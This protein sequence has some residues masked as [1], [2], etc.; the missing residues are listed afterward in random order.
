MGKKSA[1]QDGQDVHLQMIRGS[2]ELYNVS[3]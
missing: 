3:D 2:T 1:A